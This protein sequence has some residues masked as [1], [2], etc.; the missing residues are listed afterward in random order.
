MAG[1]WLVSL[2]PPPLRLSVALDSLL[3][4]ANLGDSGDTG[5]KPV[6]TP[7]GLV[8]RLPVLELR[9]LSLL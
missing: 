3:A 1:W 5:L 8:E 9:N 2:A 7:E 6:L 4:P